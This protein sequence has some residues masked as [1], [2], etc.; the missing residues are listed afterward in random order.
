M[1]GYRYTYIGLCTYICSDFFTFSGPLLCYDMC[2]ACCEPPQKPAAIIVLKT[3][4]SLGSGLM[5]RRGKTAEKKRSRIKATEPGE[6]RHWV[7]GSVVEE[8]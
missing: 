6:P 5:Q 8:I 1:A 7:C 3:P 2:W 4:H